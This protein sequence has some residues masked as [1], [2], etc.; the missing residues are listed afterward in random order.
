MNNQTRTNYFAPFRVHFYDVSFLEK[1]DFS[2]AAVEE[3]PSTL[4]TAKLK[5]LRPVHPPPIKQ[6][7]YLRSYLV[8]Q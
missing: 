2:A 7:V 8:V 4:S 1:D 5:A 6:V 3:K